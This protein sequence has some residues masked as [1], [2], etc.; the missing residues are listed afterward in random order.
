MSSATFS[1]DGGPAEAL[2]HVSRVLAAQDSQTR[3][4][5][6]VATLLAADL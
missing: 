3:A 5:K 6:E 2:E 4:H 1:V